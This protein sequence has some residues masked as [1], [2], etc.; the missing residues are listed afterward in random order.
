MDAI[1]DARRQA[2]L[3][4]RV[5]ALELLL[6]ALPEADV[7]E[8]HHLRSLARWLASRLEPEAVAAVAAWPGLESLL[9]R[10]AGIAPGHAEPALPARGAARVPLLDAASGA[11]FLAWLALEPSTAGEAMA[12]G[13]ARVAEALARAEQCTIRL[14]ARRGRLPPRAT[15]GLRWR[16][17]APAALRDGTLSVDGA[18]LGAGAAVALFSTWTELPV[19]R[20][21]LSGVLGSDGSLL[22]VEGL[23]AKLEVAQ[24]E[25][26]GL[27]VLVPAAN[28]ALPIPGLRGAA[29][30]DELL[31]AVFGPEALEAAGLD[32]LELEAEVRL[33]VELYE[34]RQSFAAA[35]EVLCAALDGIAARRR[36]EGP[37]VLRVEEFLALWRAGS[38]RVH[39]GDP[40]GASDLLGRAR[41]LGDELFDR[42]ELNPQLYL[43]SRGNFAV[44]LRDLGR[45]GDAEALL[46]ENLHLQRELRQDKRELARS[47]G[48][49]GEV[50]GVLGRYPEAEAALEEAL[51]YL[52]AVYP[53]EVPRE[54]CYLG[55]L[56]LRRGEPERALARYQAGLEENRSVESG[57]EANQ[58]FLRYGQVRALAA[59][60]RP[61]AA[62]RIGRR[63]LAALPAHR[64]Y[65]RQLLLKHLGLCELTLGEDAQGRRTLEAAADLRFARGALARFAF[66]T[67]RGELALH[68]LAQGERAPAR[69][70]A[71]RFAEASRDL[72][73]GLWRTGRAE[74]LARLA[75]EGEPQALAGALRA[76]IEQLSY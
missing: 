18:S 47:L 41:W 59:L 69:Q 28:V 15:S 63:E 39:L 45:P 38:A 44:L 66:S 14:L 1:A 70:E 35:E 17:L 48:N 25:A 42:G 10:P 6:A 58:S 34:K 60:G 46:R 36:R 13:G 37:E 20:V 8:R 68:L 57:C 55:D 53:D 43:G 73:D 64:P 61:E 49:L 67:A 56:E 12:L 72:L 29:T 62:L 21:L 22:P 3:G 65:P 31:A 50:L 40:E 5:H 4:N 24:R 52:R 71:S 74:A 76:A 16:W 9:E 7:E 33:G 54:L 11:G 27:E 32:A 23:A 26:P 75:R 2:E 51:A 19:P 30:L